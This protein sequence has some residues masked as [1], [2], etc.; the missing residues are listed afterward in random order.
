VTAA[1]IAMPQAVFNIDHEPVVGQIR[2][3][4]VQRY[5]GKNPGSG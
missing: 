5:E 3:G 2:A 4:S 1:T